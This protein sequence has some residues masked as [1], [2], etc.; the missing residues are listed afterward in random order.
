MSSAIKT[1]LL[2]LVFGLNEKMNKC[3]FFFQWKDALI[4]RMYFCRI[5]RRRQRMY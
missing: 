3:F 1:Q 4:N 5:V 2:M